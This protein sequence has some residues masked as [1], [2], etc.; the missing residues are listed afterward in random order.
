[1]SEL[2]GISAVYLSN[3]ENGV[4]SA[5]SEKVLNAISDVLELSDR[6][7]IMLFD[8]AASSKKSGTV[9]IDIAGYIKE[10]KCVSNALRT[11]MNLN[12]D[13]ADWENFIGL[14]EKK[15]LK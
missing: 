10:N 12:I 8:L 14:M 1:L 13:N 11:A 15:Y 5:P 7:K 3:I 6:E 2:I 4:R 9:A